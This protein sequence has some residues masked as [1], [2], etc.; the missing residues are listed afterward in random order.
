MRLVIVSGL[1]GAGKSVALKQYEDRGYYCIDNIPLDLVQPLLS[2]AV[3][4]PGPR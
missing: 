1:S 2:H 4:N 3:D